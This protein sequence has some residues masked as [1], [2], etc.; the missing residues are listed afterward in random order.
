[1]DEQ[2]TVDIALK[3]IKEKIF[4]EISLEIVYSQP[5]VAHSHQCYETVQ[6]WMTCYNLSGDP[7][8]DPTNI[9]IPESKGSREVEGSNIS[10]EQFT[11][12][13]KIKKVD[14]GLEDNPKFS[15][16]GDYWDEETVVKITNLLHEF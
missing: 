9:N 16:I 2:P 8:D 6:H 3:T 5:C 7:D 1:M 10:S 4:T 15:N 13:L 11:N 12:P 14:I